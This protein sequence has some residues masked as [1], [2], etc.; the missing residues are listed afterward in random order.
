MRL[1]VVLRK[2]LGQSSNAA[3]NAIGA[4]IRISDLQ[5]TEY[6]IAWEEHKTVAREPKDVAGQG[7]MRRSSAYGSILS[8]E[9]LA[10]S[11]TISVPDS[12]CRAERADWGHDVTCMCGN[13]QTPPECVGTLHSGSGIG[14]P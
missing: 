2:R 7:T 11:Q 3:G 13:V 9:P 6:G 12:S 14:Q 1:Q 8:C 5:R 4:C 10:L